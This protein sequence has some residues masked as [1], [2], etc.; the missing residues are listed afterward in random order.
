MGGIPSMPNS[1]HID[2]TRYYS[3]GQSWQEAACYVDL[4]RTK[5]EWSQILHD[6]ADQL[7]P[8]IMGDALASSTD[9]ALLIE[10]FP[11]HLKD[12]SAKETVDKE[13]N[14]FSNKVFL[15]ITREY[16]EHV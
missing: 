11:H 13:G 2:V 6:L 5:D 7:V 10:L 8:L 16:K 1:L 9:Q 4:P 3:R 14:L 12:E 15:E